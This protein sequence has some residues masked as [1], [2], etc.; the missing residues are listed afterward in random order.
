MKNQ[1]KKT[2]ILIFSISFLFFIPLII[3]ADVF[4]SIG[5]NTLEIKHPVN[6]EIKQNEPYLFVF[7]VFNKTV[8]MPI[9]AGISC[10]F[11]LYNNT[12]GHILELEEDT[13]SDLFDYSFPVEGDNFSTVGA[14]PYIISCN[15]SDQGG[16][17]STSVKVTPTGKEITPGQGFTSIGLIIAIILLA[18]LFAF[19]GFKLAETKNLFPIALFFMLISLILGV[20]TIHLGYIYTRDILYPISTEGSQFRIYIGIIWGLLAMGFIA[21]LFF[22]LKTLKEFRER[23]SI[24]K[25][26]EG[27]NPKTKSYE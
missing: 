18:G 24:L 19:F 25:Y 20:Y 16:F 7:H 8:G 27:W 10:Y 3:A 11:H 9:N 17:V 12:G 23:K 15:S 4:V 2:L 13:P 14:Y 22:I 21:L 5:D 1:I 6:Y 26:G